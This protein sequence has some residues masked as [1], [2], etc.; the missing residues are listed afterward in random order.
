MQVQIVWVVRHGH[1]GYA[2][3]DLDAANFLL[4]EMR[5]AEPGS[6]QPA[7]RLEHRQV[8]H[9]SLTATLPRSPGMLAALLQ[10]ARLAIP[11][12]V[13]KLGLPV[14]CHVGTSLRTL[15]R[16]SPWRGWQAA[17]APIQSRSHTL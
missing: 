8:W 12:S 9:S 13:Y 15:A 10:Q 17:R 4:S 2:F 7:A 3:F 5:L 1:I 16:M 14:S 11:W 6:H